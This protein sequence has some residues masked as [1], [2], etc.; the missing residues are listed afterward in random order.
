MGDE[1]PWS[2]F[3][4]EIYAFFGRNPRS[5]RRLPEFAD[6]AESQVCLDIG[7]GA[8]AAVRA[9][10]PLVTRAVG[11]DRSD[12]MV[13]IAQRRSA[14]LANTEFVAAGAEELP[15]PD[16]TFDRVWTIHAF[17]HWE[18]QSQGIA[19]CLRVLKPGGRLLI[20]ESETKGAHG[21][22]MSGANTL[23]EQLRSSGYSDASV[24]KPFKQIVVTAVA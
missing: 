22:S 23:A 8:G 19:E 12:P 17:H 3:R 11:I 20:V 10:A 1:A 5:N 24:A 16:A 18:N 21:L 2:R 6:L 13:Q 15:F 4:S 7:C 9:A 14:H